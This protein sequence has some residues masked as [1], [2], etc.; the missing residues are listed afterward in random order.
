LKRGE[1]QAAPP[2]E[3]E[4]LELVYL[5]GSRWDGGREGVDGARRDDEGVEVAGKCGGDAG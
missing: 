1:R 3:N 2:P 5:D 4:H